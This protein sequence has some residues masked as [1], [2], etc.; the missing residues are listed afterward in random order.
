MENFN[1]HFQG[2]FDMHGQEPTWGLIN[3]CHFVLGAI[4]VYQLALL[5]HFDH[6]SSLDVCL[7]AFIKAV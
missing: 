1:E 6:Y 2:I 7:E 3:T 5:Y 4:F